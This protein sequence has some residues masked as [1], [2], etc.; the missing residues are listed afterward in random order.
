MTT[1]RHAQGQVRRITRRWSYERQISVKPLGVVSAFFLPWAAYY[2]PR[3]GLMEAFD[4][5]LGGLP[6]RVECQVWMP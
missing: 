6:G 1:S 5:G 2:S 4:C 3:L